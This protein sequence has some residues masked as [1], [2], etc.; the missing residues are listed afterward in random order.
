MNVTRE[1]PMAHHYLTMA[2]ITL[3]AII[4]FGVAVS[5][6]GLLNRLGSQQTAVTTQT[7]TITTAAMR[8]NPDLL[9]LPVGQKVTLLFENNDFLAHSF[10]IDA[11]DLHIDMP[12]NGRSEQAFTFTEAGTYTIYCAVPGH[13]ESGMVG[14]LVVAGE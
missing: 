13:R 4:L 14:T 10:D 12:A 7:T 3:A 2:V 6:M 1:E 9:R 11:L 5:R 8:F